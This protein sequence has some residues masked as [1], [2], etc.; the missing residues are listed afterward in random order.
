MLSENSAGPPIPYS[1]KECGVDARSPTKL[2]VRGCADE[3]PKICESIMF[4]SLRRAYSVSN[5]F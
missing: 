1:Y 5:H 4:R 3:L 2:P